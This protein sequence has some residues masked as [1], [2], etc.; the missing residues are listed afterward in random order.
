MNLYQQLLLG[1]AA[2]VP[3]G[4]AYFLGLWATV[5]QLGRSRHPALWMLA[6]LLLRMAMLLAGFGFLAR[7]G[8]WQAVLAGLAGV[9]AV[10]V[11]L[12]RRL[13]PPPR[14]EAEEASP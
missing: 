4:A 14:R 9:L 5:R 11:Y 1:F 8:G 6:S 13:A 7:F 2:G 10:R 3:L 12:Q